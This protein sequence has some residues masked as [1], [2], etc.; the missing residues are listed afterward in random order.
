VEI[1]GSRRSRLKLL[2][3]QDSNSHHVINHG[4]LRREHASKS[5][6]IPKCTSYEQLKFYFIFIYFY[7]DAN[8]RKF[9]A[10]RQKPSHIGLKAHASQPNLRI[11]L[12]TNKHLANSVVVSFD[13]I[14]TIYPW[15]SCQ[16]RPQH[17]QLKF[18]WD[19]EEDSTRS[20]RT[21]GLNNSKGTHLTTGV[22]QKLQCFF[23]FSI[24][25]V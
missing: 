4:N 10:K 19:C 7:F 20:W 25:V 3:H 5:L 21:V 13:S 15:P 9:I 18:Q 17:E 12:K 11:K 16:F 23:W 1:H 24:M 14:N 2:R 6:C 22:Q 8:Q